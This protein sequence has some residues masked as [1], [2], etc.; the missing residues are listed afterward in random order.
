MSH[1]RPQTPFHDLDHFIAHPRV[2][3]LALSPDGRRIATIVST[4]DAKKTRYANAIWEL[5]PTGEQPARRV[6]RSAKGESGAAYD[7]DGN[8]YFISARPDPDADGDDPV[9][10][11]WMIP[12]AGGEARLVVSRPGGV[13]SVHTGREGGVL[14]VAGLLPVAEASDDPE[15]TDAQAR[16]LRKEKKVAAILHTD[17]QVRYWDADLGPDAPHVFA[18]EDAPADEPQPAADDTDADDPPTD[19]DLPGTVDAGPRKRLRLLTRG[20]GAR[21]RGGGLH[22]APDGSF[23]LAGVT[24]AVAQG[25]RNDGIVLIDVAAGTTREI[26]AGDDDV[27]H[28]PGPIGRGGARAVITTGRRGTRDT[29]TTVHL[30]LLDVASG[31]VTPLA[32][33]WD[34]W[35]HPLAWYPDGSAVLV[36]ADEDGRGPLFR[37]DA[38]SGEVTRLTDEAAYSAAAIGPDG[39]VV[40]VR[41]SYAYPSEVVRLDAAGA[42]RLPNPV[43][44][45]DLPGTLTEVETTAADG[46]RVRAW[47]CL[48][49]GAS[50]DAPAPLLLWIHGGPV[51]SW[52]AWS[53]RWTPW[54]AVAQGYAVLLPDPALSTGYGYDFLQ[55]GWGAWGDAPYTDLLAITDATEARDDIDGSRTVAMGGSFGG[56]MANWIAGHTDRFA[57]IVT[58]ASL[59]ALDQFGPTTDAP[60]Y[61]S[62]EMG[63]LA[64]AHSPHRFVG[65]ITTPMLV[66]HGDKDYRV[67]I[68]E[69]L[70][71]WWELLSAS[72][73]PADAHGQSPHRF[74]YFPDENHWILQPQHAKVWYEVVLGFVGEHV[75]GRTPTL[76][77]V[78]GAPAQG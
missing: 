47:L 76:P 29:A 56:Y 14:V 65:Q 46:V 49:E 73:L 8:L 57:A 39:T 17:A 15:K 41:S 38:G 67:P 20:L 48:P 37:V 1:R 74:L 78:L 61:W 18:V 43:E 31:A 23:A 27:H 72:G 45:P 6:T 40:G 53:W 51:G 12:A 13:Q 59:W 70:R 28:A 22:V 36:Q 26:V 75:H 58:H 64:E 34:Q 16:A 54:N 52:N 33:T 50:A 10:A 32:E 60:F 71:L 3:G 77:D 24:T 30:A 5:D 25:A 21:L 7:A 2:N 62:R 42:T 63:G 68:G 4:L 9:P 35:P 66:I 44:R 55:R 19:P 11:L 69:G